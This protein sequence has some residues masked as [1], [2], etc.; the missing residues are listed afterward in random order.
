MLLWV[1]EKNLVLHNLLTGLSHII[2]Y[3]CNMTDTFD[4]STYINLLSD[5]ETSSASPT[6]PPTSPLTPLDERYVW[7]YVQKCLIK[8]CFSVTYLSVPFYKNTR[9][10][11]CLSHRMMY[12]ELLYGEG[13]FGVTPSESSR[14]ALM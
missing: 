5:E 12:N 2:H 4:I 11:T 14:V 9:Y 6:P 7:T 10:A 13:I 3:S 8:N 1:M